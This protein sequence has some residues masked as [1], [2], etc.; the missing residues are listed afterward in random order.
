MVRMLQIWP[1]EIF[2]DNYVWVLET[3]D[4]D[5][6][7]VVDPG[8]GVPVI[9]ALEERELRVD[10]VLLTHHHHD[11]VGG[12]NDLIDRD[13]PAVY[14]SPAD[15][16]PGV[17]RPV[18]D[19][20]TIPLPGIELEVVALPGHT[21][22]HLGYIGAGVA[23]VGDTLFAGGCGRLFGGTAQQLHASL[24]RLSEL[25]PETKIYCAHEYTIANLRFAAEVEP[26]NRA[27]AERLASVEAVR[28]E[29]QPTVPSTMAYE[30]ATNPF[31]RCT[32]PSVI[33]AA[34]VRAGR[35]LSGPAEVFS[36]IRSWKDGWTG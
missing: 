1:I 27:L 26:E 18:G 24:V 30:L 5:R 19:G 35:A 9:D 14:G 13:H 10:A 7:A 21:S 25:P 32:E 20:D 11:H 12:V 31:L 15:A 8:D 36:V 22:N 2:D 17:D 3:P 29:N 28:A 16:V 33:A 4:T 23:L 6:V 34:E